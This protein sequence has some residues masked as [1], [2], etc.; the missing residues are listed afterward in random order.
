MQ[1]RVRQSFAQLQAQDQRNETVPWH[2]VNDAQSIEEVHVE[3]N[4]I[5]ERTIEQVQQ[6]SKPLEVL[7]QNVNDKDS[8]DKEN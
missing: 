6:E 3:I 8:D 1:I 2:G 4:D 5:V 7:W